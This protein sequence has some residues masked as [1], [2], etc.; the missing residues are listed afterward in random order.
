VLPLLSDQERPPLHVRTVGC[1]CGAA[2]CDA[3]FV[4]ASTVVQPE[5][6]IVAGYADDAAA[7]ESSAEFLLANEEADG[8]RP[9]LVVEKACE[10]V[11][12]RWPVLVETVGSALMQFKAFA[13]LPQWMFR[14]PVEDVRAVRGCVFGPDLTRVPRALWALHRAYVEEGPALE[15]WR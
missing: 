11:G 9:F 1:T 10:L 5:L 13:A 12:L 2:D 8:D 3:R 14:V 6:W 4:I 7:A 15:A